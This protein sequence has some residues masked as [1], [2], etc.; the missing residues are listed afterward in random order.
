MSKDSAC[1]QF[2]AQAGILLIHTSDVASFSWRGNELHGPSKTLCL[3]SVMSSAS[4]LDLLM[5]RV[6]QRQVSHVCRCAISM[7]AALALSIEDVINQYHLATA[8]TLCHFVIWGRNKVADHGGKWE[9]QSGRGC[10]RAVPYRLAP[11]SPPAR[12][13]H[14]DHVVSLPWVA[15]VTPRGER[16]AP[17]ESGE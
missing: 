8:D 2:C 11:A 3:S 14:A 15:G 4:P 10:P 9:S 5:A 12:R 13:T 7:L 1:L 16:A 6:D 17:R